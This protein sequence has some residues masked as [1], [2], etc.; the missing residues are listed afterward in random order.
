[1][2]YELDCKQLED[3]IS[4]VYFLCLLILAY[5]LNSKVFSQF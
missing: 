4:F 5:V 1:M 3:T 2:L